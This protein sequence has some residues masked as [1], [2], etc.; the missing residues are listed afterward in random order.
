[1]TTAINVWCPA[2][3]ESVM[4][5]PSG[6]CIWCGGATRDRPPARRGK[7]VGVYGKLTDDQVRAAHV[8]YRRGESLR[9][10]ARR[11]YRQAGYASA[12]SC[13]NSLH[14]HFVRLDLPRRDRI[15][16]TI[17]A[18]TTHGLAPRRGVAPEHRR[19][20][21]IARGEVLDRPL[22]A[23]VR[24]QYPNKGAPCRARAQDGSDF[25]VSHDP[26]RRHEREANLARARA[27]AGRPS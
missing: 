11:I 22:C 20:L 13:A 21:K 8:L 5:V 14:D 19:R 7:P 3:E 17:A 4:A 6:L 12:R 24:T 9:A 26:A 25:C 23:G 16:A 18:S 2:C 15:E 10:I 27:L 1:M